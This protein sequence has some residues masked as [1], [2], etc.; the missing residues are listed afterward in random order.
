MRNKIYK[1]KLV[2]KY[3]I[4][5]TLYYSGLIFIIKK[6][7]LKNNAIVLTYH[8]ILPFSERNSSF[9]HSAIMVDTINFDRQINF[10]NKHFKII[11]IDDFSKR[12]N[13]K[14][15]F[16]DCSCLITFDDG[17]LDNYKHAFPILK[18]HNIPALIFPATDYIESECLFWQEAM[19]H[20]FNQLLDN[21]K[22]DANEFLRTHDLFKLKNKP[23]LERITHIRNYVRELKKL[24]YNEIDIIIKKISKILG[25]INFGEI[26]RYLSWDQ[27]KEM[28]TNGID[29][30]SHAC[31]HRILTRL[32]ETDCMIELEKSKNLLANKLNKKIQTIAYPNG[33]YDSN[34]LKL[35]KTADYTIGFSTNFGM[36]TKK[37]NPLRVNRININDTISTNHP[38]MLCTILGIL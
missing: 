3:I 14:T 34:L 37:D 20:G 23:D 29:F 21:E 11:T 35:V 18:K 36:V 33:N 4:A 22:D 15:S 28:N 32:K 16:T 19:G 27:I 8:R 5:Y 30:G 26:D 31:S 38:I 2:I 12:I 7:K 1:I 24:P 25:K 10:I 17:W 13:S 9:S 6:F